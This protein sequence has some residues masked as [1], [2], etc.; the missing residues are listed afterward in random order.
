MGRN[1]AQNKALRRADTFFKQGNK[2]LA[3]AVLLRLLE[4]DPTSTDLR[5]AA[6][7]RL[8][9]LEMSRND[10]R[11]AVSYL[12]QALEQYH[13]LVQAAWCMQVLADLYRRLGCKRERFQIECRRMLILR[14][15][16]LTDPEPT[17]RIYA[18]NELV[19]EFE[20]RDLP[21]EADCYRKLL[22]HLVS[23]SQDVAPRL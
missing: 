18:L 20:S 15:I 13:N 7:E 1:T 2:D 14:H 23:D 22:L 12:L 21:G 4:N 19:R 11:R 16:A 8:A 3:V 10:Y 17:S 5:G 6:L 9:Y